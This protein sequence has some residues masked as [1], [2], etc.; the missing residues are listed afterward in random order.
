MIV[1]ICVDNNGGMLFH[2]RRQSRDRLLTEDLMNLFPNETIHID[3]FS[4]SL[5]LEFSDRISV[6]DSLLKNADANE[7]CFV[8]NIDI[9][10]YENKISKL[11][12]YHWNRDYPSDFRCSLDFS[13]YALT[14]SVDFEGS[15]HQRI[16]REEY[17]K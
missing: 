5:F 17:I 14:T 8:E 15:S 11:V 9:L 1:I 7:I 4:E 10:P 12:V 3:K 2:H 6:D 16:T 13:K